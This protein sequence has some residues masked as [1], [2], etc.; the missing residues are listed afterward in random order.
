MSCCKTTVPRFLIVHFFA[1]LMMGCTAP[2]PQGAYTPNFKDSDVQR[3]ATELKFLSRFMDNPPPLNTIRVGLIQTIELN[4]ASAGQGVFY[5]T[6]GFVEL[7]DSRMKRGVIAH[8]LA[9]DD[10]NHVTKKV[11]TSLVVSVI[12]FV[13]DTYIPGVGNLDRAVNPIVTRAYSRTQELEADAHAIKILTR[14]YLSEG[15]GTGDAQNEARRTVS[16]SLE[17]LRD[18][19]GATSVNL[20]STHP[21]IH[22]RIA[23]IS[24]ARD[25]VPPSALEPND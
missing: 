3:L 22:E 21:A 8:E 15:L 6:D 5:F 20:L 24:E 9:H 13:A 16:H 18:R 19:Y 4:A 14:A 10:L 12:F 7:R 2:L 23:R 11:A 1:L 25:Q 17:R